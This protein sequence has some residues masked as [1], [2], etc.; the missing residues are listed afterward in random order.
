L[1][2]RLTI[3]SVPGQEG[4]GFAC[5]NPMGDDHLKHFA[6]VEERSGEWVQTEDPAPSSQPWDEEWPVLGE[7]DVEVPE[8][9]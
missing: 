4:G 7:Y 3:V 8:G 2:K 5:L 9:D 1:V 6:P